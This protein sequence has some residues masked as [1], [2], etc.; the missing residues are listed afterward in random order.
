MARDAFATAPYR[1]RETFHVHRH[2]G[3]TMETRGILARWDAE[4]NHMTVYG[5]AKVP[6]TNRRILAAGAGILVVKKRNDHLQ[7]WFFLPIFPELTGREP[8]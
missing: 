4:K 1:R 3:I 8:P 2:T 7:F 6:F 5:A